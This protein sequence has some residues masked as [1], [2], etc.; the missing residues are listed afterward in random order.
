VT[1]PCVIT[2]LKS[3]FACLDGSANVILS[4]IGPERAAA[5]AE[6]AI[7]DGAPGL[8]SFGIAG[9][10]DAAVRAGDVVLADAVVTTCGRR[11]ETDANW[12][13]VL[14]GL[15]GENGVVHADLCQPAVRGSPQTDP[16]RS[17]EGSRPAGEHESCDLTKSF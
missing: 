1:E 8:I 10:L 6:R 9:G 15:S 16:D 4:G 13:T 11:Y 7:A 2:A 5:A 12:L 14:L 3:E 17:G